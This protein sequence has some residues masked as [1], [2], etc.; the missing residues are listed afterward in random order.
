MRF[1][2]RSHGLPIDAEILPTDMVYRDGLD[3]YVKDQDG[4]YFK[5]NTSPSPDGRVM[6]Q[7]LSERD[8]ADIEAKAAGRWMKFEEYKENILSKE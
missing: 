4:N 7:I 5:D 3:T 2:S 6:V 1:K 8:H